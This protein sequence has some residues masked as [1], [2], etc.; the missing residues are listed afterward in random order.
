MPMVD[1][2]FSSTRKCGFEKEVKKWGDTGLTGCLG[3]P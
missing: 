3:R 2:I 1:A